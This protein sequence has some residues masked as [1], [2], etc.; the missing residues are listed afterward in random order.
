ISIPSGNW[1][2]SRKLLSFNNKL[3]LIGGDA[4]STTDG[5]T[6]THT[7]SGSD[8]PLNGHLVYALNNNMFV[9]G[10]STINPQSI[11]TVFYSRDGITWRSRTLTSPPDIGAMAYTDAVLVPRTF[12]VPDLTISS[13]TF[14]QTTTHQSLT[15]PQ[16]FFTFN[17]RN[18]SNISS[19]LPAGTYFT[20]YYSTNG[21]ATYIP[22]SNYA[23][24]AP[25]P[26]PAQQ[27]ISL[28][29]E[30]FVSPNMRASLGT[31]QVKMTADATGFVQEMNE[32]NNDFL[33]TL[34]IVQ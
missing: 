17:V 29:S 28:A 10:S 14:D 15:S 33:G 30:T 22:I 31:Y 2:T 4:Y 16:V 27:S 9:L 11:P 26:F 25:V 3:W 23:L 32:N 19:T 20:L 12:G 18:N 34:T 8:L 6:W 5:I 13:L 24:S 21:G 1:S 7:Y